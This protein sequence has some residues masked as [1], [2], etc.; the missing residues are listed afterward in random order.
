MQVWGEHHERRTDR[1][2][3]T[4]GVE[5]RRLQDRQLLAQGRQVAEQLRFRLLAMVPEHNLEV[6]ATVV[7]TP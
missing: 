1:L 5:P 7:V 4:L 2:H 3:N 6:A